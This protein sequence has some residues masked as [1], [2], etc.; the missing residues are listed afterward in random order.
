M[1]ILRDTKNGAQTMH[2]EL[3][4]CRYVTIPY[5]ER[6]AHKEAHNKMIDDNPEFIAKMDKLGIIIRKI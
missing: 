6:K 4:E 5:L 2:I 3:S 1:V